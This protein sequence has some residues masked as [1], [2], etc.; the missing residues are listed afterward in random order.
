[1]KVWRGRSYPLGAT[2]D[3]E[4]TNFALFSRNA[5]AVELCLFDR[6]GREQRIEIADHD[7]FVW[8]CYLPGIRAGQRY[9]YRVHGPYE[10][11]LGHRFNATKLLLDP[12]AGLIEGDVPAVDE[13]FGYRRGDPAE[14]LSFDERDS[15]PFL[16]KSMV[17]DQSFDWGDDRAPRTPLSETLIYEAHV[18]GFTL[19]HPDVPEGVRGTYAG[20]ACEAALAHLR[21]LGVT[22]VELLP[23]HHH[24]TSR[25]LVE[26]GLTNYWGYNTVGFF[27]PDTRLA[28]TGDPVRDVKAMVRELHAAGIEV[29]L[30]VVYNHT[31]EGDELGPTVLF[32]GID[33]ASYYRLRPD[34]RRRYLDYTGTGNTLDT[35]EPRV[36]QLIMDSL[37]QWVTEYHVDG[38]R[39]DLAATLAREHDRFDPRGGFFDAIG[40]DPVLSRVKLIAEPW[41][42]GWGGYQVGNFPT[43]WSE[44]NG[45]YR[46]TVRRFW[47]GDVG[48]A[49]EL[50]FRLTGSSDLYAD[51]GRRPHASINYVTA[52]DGFTLRDLV[53]YE[54]KHNEANGEGN[55]DGSN[56]NASRNFGVEGPS[57]DPAVL[58]ARSRAQRTLRAT[59]LLSQGVPM[60]R[61]GDELGQT[62]RG[63]N[64]AYAQDNEVSWLDWTAADLGL[65]EF[66][67]GLSALARSHPVLHR[68]HF[69]QGRPLAG[70]ALKDLAWFAP[71]GSEMTD[72][73]WPF[74]HALALR[75][76]GDAIDEADAHGNPIADDTL[77]LLLNAA[78]ETVEFLLP[79]D[80]D[81]AWGLLLDTSSAGAPDGTAGS[82]HAT[83][84][85]YAL[86]PGALALF[87]VSIADYAAA[88]PVTTT[89]EMR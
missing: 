78:A 26:Q 15:A 67:A 42:L 10:P 87:A 89:E 31:G 13:L 57:T 24:L 66:V 65:F 71:D 8:H 68:H 62:Q 47:R 73:D 39:F 88:T 2:P 30:D 7:E 43:G 36:L 28:A 45:R 63:N 44:W 85:T 19:L 25:S 40:Q 82:H 79:A 14:D 70:A 20:L 50:A 1:M 3:A 35:T 51:D 6:E 23:I 72:A 46:D 61:A 64:N 17:I 75:L 11:E 77:L 18:R 74:T 76:A 34:D 21:R 86:A 41:D 32:R 59:L 49:P 60:L 84:T 56:D 52:H 22:A 58:E 54:T 80:H 38:F 37:R 9:G 12:Y 27:A 48:Q 55:R 33:N 4:G 53:S 29:I 69:L 81:G 5:T 16:P 83:G